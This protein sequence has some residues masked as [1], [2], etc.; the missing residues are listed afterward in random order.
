MC[1]I[2]RE[3]SD[4]E[5]EPECSLRTLPPDKESSQTGITWFSSVFLCEM[6]MFFWF[7]ENFS[8]QH[9]VYKRI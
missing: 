9:K 3:P 2:H 6:K 8:F 7:S 1:L 5:K 4:L